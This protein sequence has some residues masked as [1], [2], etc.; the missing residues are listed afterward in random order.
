MVLSDFTNFLEFYYLV[1]LFLR[2]LY[3]DSPCCWHGNCYIISHLSD[4]CAT[5]ITY[6]NYILLLLRWCSSKHQYLWLPSRCSFVEV[7]LL[8]RCFRLPCDAP[9]LHHEVCDIP[10]EVRCP[11]HLSCDF[12][13]L[14]SEEVISI[15]SR[16]SALPYS[17][18]CHFKPLLLPI[19][20]VFPFSI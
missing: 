5:L 19:G 13:L 6:Y 17:P 1:I 10:R 16:W 7:C 9:V 14:P 8:S 18:H 4:P 3:A 15:A 2:P 11:A 20:L 12:Y